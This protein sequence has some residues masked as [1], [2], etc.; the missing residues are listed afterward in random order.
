VDCD[1]EM[2]KRLKRMMGIENQDKIICKNISCF[3]L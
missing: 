2:E 1:T 3:V